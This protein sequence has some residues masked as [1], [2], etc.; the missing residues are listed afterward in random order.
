MYWEIRRRRRCTT[1][2]AMQHLIRTRREPGRASVVLE[3][4][5]VRT[6]ATGS[7]ISKAEIWMI[8]SEISLEVCSA[9]AAAEVIADSVA[10]TAR[11]LEAVPI[12]AED[13]ISIQKF[14]SALMK[15]HLD[16]IR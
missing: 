10:S 6:A 2:S 8:F 1:S 16:A 15:P 12:R 11:D 14:R 13:R 4:S 3:V 5:A 7:S 9:E